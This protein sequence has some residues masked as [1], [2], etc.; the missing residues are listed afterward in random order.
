MSIEQMQHAR[1][2]TIALMAATLEAG[3]RAHE[4]PHG[5]PRIG[6]VKEYARRA[7]QLFDMVDQLEADVAVGAGEP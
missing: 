4:T 3:D 1:L 6:P 2:H 5:D 7:M